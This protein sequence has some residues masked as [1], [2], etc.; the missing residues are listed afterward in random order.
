VQEREHASA[1]PTHFSEAQLLELDAQVAEDASAVEKVRTALLE[2]DEAL[3]KAHKD[4]AGMQTVAAEWE[5]EV[6][7]T[8]AQLQQDRATLEGARAWQSP[9]EEKAKE[10]EQLR[11][12]MADKAASL[13]STEEQ[14]QQ[15]RDARQ[16]A[17]AQLQQERTA[18]AEARAALERERLAREE[19][20]GLLQ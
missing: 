12:S 18:L 1:P 3:R 16:Q 2:W 5:A 14:L 10:V 15:E 6:A 9:A 20:Q 17:E 13:A 19:A 7:T 4:L 8:R 11:T